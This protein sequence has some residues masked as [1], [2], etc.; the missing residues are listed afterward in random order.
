MRNALSMPNPRGPAA[1]D[2]GPACN[3]SYGL[4]MG[5]SRDRES[6]GTLRVSGLTWISRRVL[7]SGVCLLW[8]HSRESTRVTASR[9]VSFCL[10]VYLV[11]SLLD[12]V[13]TPFHDRQYQDA[14]SN[15]AVPVSKKRGVTSYR[16]YV[17]ALL[18]W[19]RRTEGYGT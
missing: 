16:C 17:V 5:L 12:P 14:R 7:P 8:S 13:L 18:R 9:G 2:R 3:L 1:H 11:L 10:P 6:N 19:S 4:L 15:R